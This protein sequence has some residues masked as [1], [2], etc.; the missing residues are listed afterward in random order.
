MNYFLSITF[1]LSFSF[2][3]VASTHEEL[4]LQDKIGQMLILGF[5]GKQV[6][7]QSK[8]VQSIQK[9]NLGGVILFDYNQQRHKFDKNIETPAQVKQLTHDLQTFAHKA[10]LDHHRPNVPLLIS[11]D[12][13]GGH[14]TRLSPH[15]GF[16]KTLAA[17]EVGK[18]GTHAAKKNAQLL[19]AVL[20]NTGFNLNFAP[21]VD[22]RIN[23]HNP[24]IAQKERSFSANPDTVISYARIY[25]QEFLKNKIQCTYKHFPGHGSS[26]N[27]S[28][29]GFVDVTNT[30]KPEELK[31]YQKLLNKHFSCGFIMS[32]HIIN[33]H[34]DSSGLPATLSHKIL[35]DLLRGTLHFKGVVITD[36]MQMNAI[37]SHYG[38]EKALV[39]AINAGAD[40]LIF[41]NT[42]TNQ[43]QDS[44]QL[45]QIIAKKVRSGEISQKR[46]DEAYQHIMTLKKTLN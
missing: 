24:I 23:P 29:L 15:Y 10:N 27:D 6:N 14:V 39:L 22:L 11:V 36:D 17:Y 30:W 43:K 35:T 12:Y 45:I 37:S 28:H 25:S 44:A 31:P 33:R 34:L 26:Q 4:S 20:M 9:D 42:L 46:I 21:L 2:S 7:S 3:C 13:E 40:M 1:F 16:P 19:S 41:G 5:E 18:K 38:L 8:I 32:A